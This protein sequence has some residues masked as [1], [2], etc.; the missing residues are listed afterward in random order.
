MDPASA[1]GNSK[2]TQR[3]VTHRHDDAALIDKIARTIRAVLR[4]TL[5][6]PFNLNSKECV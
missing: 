3:V 1:I 2:D 5:A 6:I 4:P